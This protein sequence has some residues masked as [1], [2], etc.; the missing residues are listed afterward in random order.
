MKL[1]PARDEHL[2]IGALEQWLWDAACAIRGATD[3]PKFKDFI[4]P[5]IFYKRISDVF[6]DEFEKQIAEWGDAKDAYE[7]VE[8]DHADALRAGRRDR[9]TRF[10]I[11]ERYA[12]DKVRNH[13]ANGSLGE[14]ITKALRDVAQLNPELQ[15]IFESIDYNARQAGQR[16]LDDDRLHTLIEVISRHRLGLK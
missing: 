6:A 15:G 5:L 3:A 2:D 16:I 8:A 1:P 9:L 12:W 10:Y 11:P 7:V 14:F 4:L 13:P